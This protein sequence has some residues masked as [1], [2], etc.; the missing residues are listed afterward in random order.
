MLTVV[1]I[2]ITRIAMQRASAGPAEALGT[3]IL[4]SYAAKGVLILVGIT[5][6]S[7]DEHVSRAAF[8]LTL[9][10]GIVTNVALQAAALAAGQDRHGA[11]DPHGD[12]ATAYRR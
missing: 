8:G 5:L 12:P 2:W 10:A 9:V 1:F 11:A 3:W 6:A 4:V 7:K